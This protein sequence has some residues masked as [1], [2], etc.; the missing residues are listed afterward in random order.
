MGGTK[1]QA[2]IR[3]GQRAYKEGEHN[4]PPIINLHE[5]EGYTFAKGRAELTPSFEQK[6]KSNI[7]PGLLELTRRY[8]AFQG[9]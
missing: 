8:C 1:A 5:A 6:L 7:I 4:W 2:F 3:L 9:L